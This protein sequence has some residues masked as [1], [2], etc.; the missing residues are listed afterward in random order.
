[1]SIAQK[2]TAHEAI[3]RVEPVVKVGVRKRKG[4]MRQCKTEYWRQ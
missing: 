1:L 4:D 3:D 2:K